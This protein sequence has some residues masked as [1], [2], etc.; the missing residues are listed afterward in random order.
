V[1]RDL[2]VAMYLDLG[3]EVS[4]CHTLRETSEAL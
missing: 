4:V 2:V 1:R 3:I